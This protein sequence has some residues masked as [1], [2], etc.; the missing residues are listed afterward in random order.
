[1]KIKIEFKLIFL[2]C[3]R[4]K[5]IEDSDRQSYETYK[6]KYKFNMKNLYEL[7]RLI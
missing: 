1:M 3:R 6:N 2:Y 4:V 5:I 7:Y